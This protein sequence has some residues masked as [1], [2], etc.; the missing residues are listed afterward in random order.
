[1]PT[2]TSVEPQRH[3]PKRFNIFLDGQFS[4]GADQD[5]IVKYRLLP[6]KEIKKEDLKKLL[7]E[8]KIGKLI[9]RIYRLFGIRMRSEAEVRQYFRIKN[10]E[11]RT[12]GKEEVSELVVDQLME[13]LKK[14]G[15]VNDLEF[16]RSWVESRRRSK[17]LGERVLRMELI[18]KGISREII[19]QV[20]SDQVTG[21]S[22]E[23]LAQEALAK[24]LPRLKGFPYLEFRK[25]ATE[26]L[27]RKGFGYGLIKEVVE[28][29]MQKD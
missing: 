28:K 29:A 27:L 2:V 6:G 10:L 4:F 9:E 5:L 22:E 17:K 1:M 26:Y 3:S 18:K 11:H 20:I 16:A 12:K 25:K 24:R 21:N 8:T 23:K 19:D 13:T 15:L 7:F 14:K